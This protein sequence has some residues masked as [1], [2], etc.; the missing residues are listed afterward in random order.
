MHTSLGDTCV[1]AKVNGRVVPLRTGLTNGDQVEILRSKQPA[2]DPAWENF[3]VSVKARS[4]VR[5]FVRQQQRG[6]LLAMGRK[7]YDEIVARL[8]LPLSD[9]AVAAALTRL[10]LPDRNAL[11]LGL[12]RQTI[13]DT[14]VLEAVLPGSTAGLK[15]KG[16]KAKAVQQAA[17]SIK[18]LTPGVAFQ[19]A[20]CFYPIPGDRIVGVRRPGT[21]IEVHS[22][23]CATLEGENG[24]W[25]DLAWG[26]AAESAV[27]RLAA[28]VRNQPGSL[29]ALTAILAHH[30]ANI[31]N[32][33]LKQRDRE[34][35]TFVIDVEVDDL[36]HLTNII[37]ALRATQAV[38]SVER[39]KA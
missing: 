8:K 30:R 34:F 3:V 20:E 37:A 7:L 10:K 15:G 19:L 28:V 14:A 31:V 1:G 36:A 23:D 38:V 22:I 4:A 21:G 27:T 29:A 39:V 32:L 9:D 24:E 2:P 11:Y 26:E 18:G 13:A 33:A 12:A 25:L 35:H 17:I 6:E 5:R 16:R